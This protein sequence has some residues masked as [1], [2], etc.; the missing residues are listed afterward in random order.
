MPQA[1]LHLHLDAISTAYAL[2]HLAWRPDALEMLPG[3][4][5]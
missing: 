4:T 2:L 1:K 3:N 5:E